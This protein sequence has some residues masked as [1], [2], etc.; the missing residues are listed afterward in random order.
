MGL[1]LAA[2]LAP[3]SSA[4]AIGKVTAAP[5]ATPPAPTHVA[6]DFTIYVGGLLFIQ[7]NFKAAVDDDKYRLAATM[8]TAGTT[9]AFY[10]ADY[11]LR[12][13]GWLGGD[14]VKPRHYVSDST[15]K[16]STRL[17]TMSYTRDG[18]PRLSAVPPYDPGDLDEVMPSL[19]QGTQDP[20]SAFLM[21]VA[22]SNNPC[23]RTIPVFDGKRR[24]DLKLAYE[25]TKEMTP[26]GLDHSVTTVVCTIRYVAIAPV[27]RR[28]FT[29]MLRRNDDM[30]VWLA[31]FDGGRI[32]M[33]VRFQLRTPL[34][35]A[36][37]ELTRVTERT[38]SLTPDAEPVSRAA[39]K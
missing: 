17:V 10:P 6:A 38:A 35:G 33:P 29:D 23:K 9:R 14:S 36:V 13:E 26:R 11:K 32:Y 3:E 20:M 30:K 19:Q 15:S 31:P 8:G 22:A 27:E 1:A 16:H 34:G 21:P 39:M 28:K 4:L 7:G 5:E 18:M 12:S 25:G 24:Y 37:M 2:L